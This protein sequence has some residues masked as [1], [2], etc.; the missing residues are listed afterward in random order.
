MLDGGT[1]KGMTLSSGAVVVY[2]TLLSGMSAK[3]VVVAD[4][5]SQTVLSSATATGARV[6]SGGSITLG[7]GVVK[8]LSVARGGTVYVA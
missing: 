3:N 1:T 6:L 4:G 8:K 2:E 5:L 7:G